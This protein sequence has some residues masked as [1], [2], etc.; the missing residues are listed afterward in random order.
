MTYPPPPPSNDWFPVVSSSIQ[1]SDAVKVFDMSLPS[2]DS[3]SNPKASND[4]MKGADVSKDGTEKLGVARKSVDQFS[5]MP[6]V[7]RKGPK[8]EA[9]VP[10]NRQT[11]EE[12]LK[13]DMEI[14]G[15]DMPKYDASGPKKNALAI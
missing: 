12:A 8:K 13:Q 15:M 7:A 10:A 2:Y 1:L 3:A 14:V 5:S 4:I 9:Y 6:G 11:R